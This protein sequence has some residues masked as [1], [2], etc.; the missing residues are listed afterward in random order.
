[1]PHLK[2]AAIVL[3]NADYRENDRMLTLL[4]PGS[5]R[6]E[7]VCR[8]CR[9]PK[10]PLLAASECFCEGEY[11]LYE[12]RGHTSVTACAVTDSFYPLREDYDLLRYAAYMLAVCEA[13]AQPGLASLDLFTLLTRSLS[14][15]AYLHMEPK[16]VTAA[17]LLLYSAASGYR[18]RLSEC[19]RCGRTAG[20]DEIRHFDIEEGGLCCTE[21]ARSL[22]PAAQLYPLVFSGLCWMRDVLRRG[23]EKTDCPPED[24][25]LSLLKVYVE[26]R[27]EK[28]LPASRGI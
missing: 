25:P 11:M 21:C 1:M 9:R 7:A 8:G 23:I 18:P 15:L 3:R 16:S 22:P 5:G 13:A 26:S 17:F 4:T 12:N 24:A 6:V 19:V 20:T 28:K 2:T 27:L 14:R 10:S